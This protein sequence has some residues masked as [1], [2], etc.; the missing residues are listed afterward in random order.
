MATKQKHRSKHGA[1]GQLQLA[2]RLLEKGDFKQALK[3]AKL[4]YRQEPSPDARQLLERAHLARGRQLCRAGLRAESRAVVENLLELG[5]TDASVQGELP[6]LLIALGLFNRIAVAGGSNASVEEGS[7]L[8]ATAADHAVLWPEGAPASLPAIRRGAE[9][10]RRALVALEA[11]NEADAMAELKDI[12]AH[13][14]LPTGSILCGGWR[15]T[16]AKKR[17]RCKRIGVGSTR[18]GWPCGLPPR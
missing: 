6:E 18:G 3:N 10:I 8:Y 2:Q 13:R 7:P 17:R 9:S 14:R 5:A 12:S 4:C 16:I 11:G 1:V 15:P